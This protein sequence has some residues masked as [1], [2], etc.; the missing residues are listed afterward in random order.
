MKLVKWAS[1]NHNKRIV[2][3]TK[4]IA[5]AD[6]ICRDIKLKIRNEN[7]IGNTIHS[8]SPARGEVRLG[9]ET[10]IMITPEYSSRFRGLTVDVLLFCDN[11]GTNTIN[12]IKRHMLPSMRPETRTI[13]VLKT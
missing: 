4:T 3:I 10:I 2:I 7:E 11:M 6:H 12:V 13:G 8:Y 1:E 5:Q 9:N